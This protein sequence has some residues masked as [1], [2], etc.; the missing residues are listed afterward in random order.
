ML[1]IERLFIGGFVVGFI[2]CDL[3]EV[4]REDLL[5]DSDMLLDRK[6][7]W[8]VNKDVCRMLEIGDELCFYL[9]FNGRLIF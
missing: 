5:D 2:V 7:Y 1:G 4:I 6:E 9:I 8:V 3:R